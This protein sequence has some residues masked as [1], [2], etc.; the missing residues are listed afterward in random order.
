MSARFNFAISSSPRKVSSS[1]L[2]TL[3]QAIAPFPVMKST[4]KDCEARQNKPDK[5]HGQ[6][7]RRWPRTHL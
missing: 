4:N 3:L 2:Q 5:K 7:T 6:P 1:D